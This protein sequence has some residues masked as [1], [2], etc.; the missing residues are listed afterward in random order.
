MQDVKDALGIFLAVSVNP[1][2]LIIDEVLGVAICRFKPNAWNVFGN[3]VR[4]A[5]QSK[6]SGWITAA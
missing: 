6:P 2:I 5:R 1:D 3:S 4:P